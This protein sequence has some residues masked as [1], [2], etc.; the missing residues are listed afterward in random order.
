MMIQKIDALRGYSGNFWFKKEGPIFGQK[1][2]VA[3]EMLSVT[4]AFDADYK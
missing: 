2:A 4:I 1:M 3:E